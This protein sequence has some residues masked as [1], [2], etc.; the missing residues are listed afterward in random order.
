VDVAGQALS[1]VVIDRLPFQPLGDPLVQARMEWLRMED[2]DPFQHLQIPQA[3][4]SLKQG[5]GRLIRNQQDRGVVAIL[6]KRI[7]NQGYGRRFLA[8]LPPCER[9]YDLDA[10]RKWC[11]ENLP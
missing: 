10:L 4:L 1:C 11:G 7:R 2:R 8:A 5:F 9:V 6:D 3:I